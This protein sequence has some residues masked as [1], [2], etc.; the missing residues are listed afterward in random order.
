M[1]YLFLSLSILFTLASF[2]SERIGYYCEAAHSL[3]SSKYNTSFN[4][5]IDLSSVRDQERT[6][7]VDVYL[8]NMS[9]SILPSRPIRGVYTVNLSNYL[10]TDSLLMA[11]LIVDIQDGT[12]SLNF[13]TVG[14][15]IPSNGNF[16]S[17]HLSEADNIPL[18]EGKCIR[19]SELD[20]VWET[21]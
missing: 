17:L 18:D 15:M 3:Y 14:I 2:P 6:K 21:I 1:K 8:E 7:V 9:S 5:V 11:D 13:T 16:V 12:S 20:T 19:R 4:M 10:Q